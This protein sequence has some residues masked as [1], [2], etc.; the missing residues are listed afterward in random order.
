MQMAM[1]ALQNNNNENKNLK[2]ANKSSSSPNISVAYILQSKRLHRP[3]FYFLERQREQ[4]WHKY[5][6]YD[7]MHFWHE[8][9]HTDKMRTTQCG[10]PHVNKGKQV[11]LS[12][13]SLI[14]SDVPHI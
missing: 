12:I 8:Q 2:N 6:R 13:L 7:L 5:Q 9:R 14:N 4:L 3:H 11:N 1:C 10:F